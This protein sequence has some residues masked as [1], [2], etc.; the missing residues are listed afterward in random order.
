ML[1]SLASG[2]DASLVAKNKTKIF[3]TTIDKIITSG[4]ILVFDMSKGL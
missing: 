2:A 1:G 4:E 3:S